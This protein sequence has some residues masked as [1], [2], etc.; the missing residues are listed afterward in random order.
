MARIAGVD[1]PRDKRLDIALTYIYGVGTTSATRS[2]SGSGVERRHEGPRPLRGRGAEDPRLHRPNFKVEGDLR[3]EVAQDIKRKIEIGCY[4][5]VRHRR[6]PP[7]PRAAHAHERAHPQGAE[8][9]DRRQEEGDQE[10]VRP[11]S[12]E[13]TH[14]EAQSEEDEASARRSTS[15]TGRRTSSRRSTTRSSRSPTCRATRSAG[16]APATW[17]SRARASRRR[18]PRSSPPRRP[19]ARRRSTACRRSTCS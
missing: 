18:S 10:V 17:A 1:L 6:G 11:R 7:G 9:D 8:E 15:S 12:E 5:G 4:Q 14:G 13:H 2:S 16:R 19:R 3:R